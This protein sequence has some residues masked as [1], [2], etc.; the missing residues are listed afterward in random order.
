[1]QADTSIKTGPLIL[2]AFIAL[3]IAFAGFPIYVHGPDYYASQFGVSL[4]SLASILLFLRVI[5]GL[6]DPVIGIVCDRYSDYRPYILI[7][8]SL[9][10]VLSFWALFHPLFQNQILLWFTVSVFLVTSAY[11][12]L[13]INVTA[14]GGMWTTMKHER[15]RIAM[16]RESLG[17]I[18][19]LLA[20]ILPSVLTLQMMPQRAFTIMFFVLAALLSFGLV[21]FLNWYFKYRNT[22]EISISK[23]KM[24]GLIAT[25][26]SLS[27][28]NKQFFLI[29]GI[30]MLAS[31]IPAVLVI[32]YI[33]D[34]LAAQSYL[35]LFLM[36]YF[37]SG[38]F[39]MVFWTRL[40]QKLDSKETTWGLAM[41]MAV[42]TFCW[43]LLIEPGDLFSYG[44]ICIASGLAFGAELSLPPSIL[45]DHI[46]DK[47]LEAENTFIFAQ[48]TLLA[49][50]S[51]AGATVLVFPLLEYAGFVPSEQNEQST[52]MLLVFCYAGLPSLIKLVSIVLLF[53]HL[54]RKQIPQGT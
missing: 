27:S 7:F 31:S 6:Q 19:L 47:K 35:G 43:V 3:P 11:S 22:I 10:L 9:I 33:R 2:Y 26:K 41:V 50:L 39:G 37:L 49:K 32:F 29:Y 45:A 24:P 46:T 21:L 38:A 1:M 20:V 16:Y 12:V 36:L 14:L 5:D 18:G 54:K 13:V 40:S 17:L 34:Y 52:L 28:R 48:L 8:S 44:I 25:L 42:L 51:L 23:T 4:T 30:S 53:H 15:T